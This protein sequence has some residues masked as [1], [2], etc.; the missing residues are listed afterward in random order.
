M[1]WPELLLLFI[2]QREKRGR[3]VWKPDPTFDVTL[4]NHR[5]TCKKVV[6]FL[7]VILPS[8]K[9]VFVLHCID[10]M[11]RWDILGERSIPFFGHG[12]P[13]FWGSYRASEKR[14][15]TISFATTFV[16]KRL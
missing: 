6:S 9:V 1:Q 16:K 12:V 8:A 4:K 15:G 13:C 11:K 2:W 5:K 3:V 7:S 10:H 14:V